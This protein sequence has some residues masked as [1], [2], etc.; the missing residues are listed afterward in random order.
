MNIIEFAGNT[1]LLK[2]DGEGN[3]SNIVP[4]LTRLLSGNDG[5]IDL[6]GLVTKFQSSGV[7]SLVTSWVGE[8]ENNPI[9]GDQVKEVFGEE[10]ISEFASNA[11]LSFSTAIDGLSGVI[12]ELINQASSGEFLLNSTGGMGCLS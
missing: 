1:F 2:T 8:G 9:P 5:N 12:P 7:P 3:A 4:A 11:G 10:K 6:I